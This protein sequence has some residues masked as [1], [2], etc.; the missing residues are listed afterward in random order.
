LITALFFCHLCVP[1]VQQ[2]TRK[3]FK[4]A[5]YDPDLGLYAKGADD[6]YV[7]VYWIVLFT[8]LR[9]AAMDY[10]FKPWAERGGVPS[11]KGRVRFAEQA[12]QMLYYGI[13]WS[14]G[15]VSHLRNS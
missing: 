6:I 10:V 12:W 1:G 4:L 5:Y 13:F 7:V 2:Y 14:I 8:G 3:F 15:F 9:A 11:K